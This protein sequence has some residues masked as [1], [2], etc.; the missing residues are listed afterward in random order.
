M[1]HKMIKFRI[2]GTDHRYTDEGLLRPQHGK[3]LSPAGA[4]LRRGRAT[5]VE[6]GV[7][8]RLPTSLSILLH[9]LLMVIHFD[10]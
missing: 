2:V 6:G 1:T 5:G 8:A 3:M 7:R 10:F 9:S 4:C